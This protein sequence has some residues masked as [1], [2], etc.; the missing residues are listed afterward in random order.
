MFVQVYRRLHDASPVLVL[1]FFDSRGKTWS[2]VLSY[3]HLTVLHTGGNSP[4]N[5]SHPVPDYVDPSVATWIASETAGMD[6]V[7]GPS[8]DR[9]A[10]AFVHIP[11]YVSIPNGR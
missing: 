1:W 9:G 7:W 11:P 8:E 2:I 10:L 5:D 3:Y 6:A 4:G